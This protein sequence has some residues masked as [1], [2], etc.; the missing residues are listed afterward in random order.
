MTNPV[1]GPRQALSLD[2]LMKQGGDGWDFFADFVGLP[3]PPAPCQPSDAVAKSLARLVRTADGR[4]IAEWLMDI[5]LRQPLRITG[6][7]FEQTALM[8]A[9]RQ[10]IDGVAHSVLAAIAHGETLIAAEEERRP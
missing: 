6:A 3:K 9:H 7:S 8:A 1:F 5:T 10:G 2:D 4:E